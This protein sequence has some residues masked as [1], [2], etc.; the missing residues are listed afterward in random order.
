MS[1]ATRM[2]TLWNPEFEAP[3]LNQEIIPLPPSPPLPPSSYNSHSHSAHLAF[4][5]KQKDA[6]TKCR[7]YEYDSNLKSPS[8][9]SASKTLSPLVAARLLGWLLV[10]APCAEGRDALAED[11]LGCVDDGGVRRDGGESEE[12][13][14]YTLSLKWKGWFLRY[15]EC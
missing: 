1:A 12:E 14:L 10:C 8:A 7:Q 5:P 4:T 2:H 11:I 3:Y 13:T 6:Y 15:C 9:R